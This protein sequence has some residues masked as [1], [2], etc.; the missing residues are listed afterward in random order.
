MYRWIDRHGMPAHRADRLWK[1]KKNEV[2]AWLK[3][4]DAAE[5]SDAGKSRNL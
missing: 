1:L 4:G 2:D 5:P 3:A